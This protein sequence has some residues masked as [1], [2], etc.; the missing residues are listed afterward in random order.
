MAASGSL[1]KA[2]ALGDSCTWFVNGQDVGACAA[3]FGSEPLAAIARIRDKELLA[4]DETRGLVAYRLFEDLPAVGGT[5]G[6][7]PRTYQVVVLLRFV[8]GRIEQVQAFTSELPYG[9]KPHR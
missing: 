7:Y 1:P 8:G 6:A 9:M 3:A 5:A 2:A 4:A